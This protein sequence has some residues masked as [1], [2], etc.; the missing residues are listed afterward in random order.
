MLTLGLGTLVITLQDPIIKA[1][2][3]TYPVMEAVA[4]RSVV[5]LPIFLVL[6][7]RMGGWRVA[8]QANTRQAVVRAL[9]FMTAY[10]AYF[11]AFP[12]MPLADVVALYFTAPLFVVLLSRPYLGE[13]QSLS[14]WLAV[15][16]GFAGALVVA[17]PGTGGIGWA[18]VLPVIAAALYAFGQLM[19]RRYGED[20]SATVLSFHQN[21]VYLVGAMVFSFIAAPFAAAPGATG[22][23]A[24]LTRAWEVPDA[25]DLVLLGLC[26][27]I[28]V[29]GTI[30]LTKAYREAPPG[31][32]TPIEYMALIWDSLWG[33]LLFAEI[34]D[35]ATIVGAVLIIASGVFAV[36]RG[37]A[38]ARGAT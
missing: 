38:I 22:S 1:T 21:W 12:A 4:I 30:L 11:L 29:G 32:V 8:F 17:Q 14:R 26:G 31:A 10:T 3:D 27:P 15:L 37:A 2:M 28:A 6:L 25:K 19:A 5:A 16:V 7:H 23:L 36:T 34:P 18:A 9:L 24:F 35:A 20:T 13:R 33:F